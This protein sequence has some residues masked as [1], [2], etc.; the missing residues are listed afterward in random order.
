MAKLHE[1]L[2]VEQDV[3]EI[4][5]KTLKETKRVF[6]NEVT[7]FIGA[8]RTLTW[9]DESTPAAPAEHQEMT[10][11]VKAVLDEQQLNIIRYFDALLQKE[12][13]NQEAK[14]DLIVD[15]L[16]IAYDLPATFLLGL[17]SRLKKIRN[18][19]D[20]IPILPPSIKWVK[21][22]TKG[23]DIYAREHPEKQ[24][25]TEQIIK[26]QVLYEA[27]KEHPA[28]VDKVQEKVNVGIYE[29]NVWTGVLSPGEKTRILGRINKLIRAVKKARQRANTTDVVDITIGKEIFDYINA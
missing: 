12:R 6:E 9:Y 24:Y 28:Q 15:G 13:T 25:K 29:K 19:Y 1:L 8:I 3:E 18:V 17:E 5:N 26:P 20:E 16:T 2:A 21:D 7:K 11:T 4:Y 10:T 27:T 22:E 23:P 14:T